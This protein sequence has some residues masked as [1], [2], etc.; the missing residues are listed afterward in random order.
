MSTETTTTTRNI[1]GSSKK[2]AVCNVRVTLKINKKCI[3][4]QMHITKCQT[5]IW[6]ITKVFEILNKILTNDKNA[7]SLI[8]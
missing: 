4:W 1:V 6:N 5:I 7:R 8:I 2:S 3:K